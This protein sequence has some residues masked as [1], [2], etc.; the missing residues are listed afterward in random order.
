MKLA[1]LLADA[2][3]TVSGGDA[4]V[5]GFAIDHRKV[6]P[7]TVFGAFQGA[8]FDGEAF[9]ADAVRAGAVAVVARPEAPVDGA[10]HIADAN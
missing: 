10:L 7:G 8:R 4:E 2:G 5:T 3:L 9:I 1:R 6:A